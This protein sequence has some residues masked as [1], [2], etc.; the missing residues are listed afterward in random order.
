[1]TDLL[2]KKGITEIGG[3]KGLVNTYYKNIK[4]EI[5]QI[6]SQFDYQRASHG[7]AHWFLVTIKNLNENSVSE[8]ITDGYHDWGIDAINIDYDKELIELYQFK[9]P[10]VEKNINKSISKNEINTFLFGYKVCSSGSY[11]NNAN[12]ELK[13]K[14]NEISVSDIF[15][16][17]LNYVSY[18]NGL[19][20]NAEYTL[21]TELTKIKETG[22]QITWE[23]YDKTN[24]TNLLYTSKRKHKDFYVTLNQVGSSTGIMTT[25]NS[26]TYV[27]SCPLNELAKVCEEHSNIIFDE[28]VRLFHG[29]KNIYNQGI[30]NT[31]KSSD[32]IN[33]HLYN[34]G[35]VLIAP[36]VKYIDTAK[37]LKIK[38]P[39]VVNGC[40]TMN[41]IV[42]A[43][44]DSQIK[45][46]YV[47]VK[48]IE[49]NDPVVRQNISIYLNS[50]TEI[51]DSYLISNLP[52]VRQLEQDLKDKGYILE[53]QA[54]QIQNM[55]KQ[56]SVKEAKKVFGKN[57]SQ[58]IKLETA[59]QVYAVFFEDMAPIA[60]LNKAKLFNNKKNLEKIFKNLN[61][62]KVIFSYNIYTKILEKIS[63]FRKFKRNNNN[64]DFLNYIAITSDDINSYQFMNTGDLFLLSVFS[65]ICQKRIGNYEQI[66]KN[67]INSKDKIQT[68]R[69]WTIKAENMFD[70]LLINSINIFKDTVEKDKSGKP[71]SV[72]TKNASFHRE[73]ISAVYNS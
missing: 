34:N 16:Y 48:A 66:G 64:Q 20:E 55:R 23:L 37:K 18:T 47:Q 7:F 24:I 19:D 50:Q 17:Q 70:E 5:N 69:D 65:K 33:F 3:Y 22:N 61:S 51:K 8:M 49:I 6:I 2:G 1:M 29:A 28:N 53:R 35:V 25:D 58:V 31:A 46:G 13:E 56:M 44:K 40:Q 9:F 60:K 67:Q 27:I 73:L 59:I 45:D 41:S 68:L 36:E 11:P 14:I 54:N 71:I 30:I 52:I 10:D 62:D 43:A 63:D 42:E 38:N 72:M 15:D 57:N 12:I 39:M 4:D 26:S 21:E 32:S